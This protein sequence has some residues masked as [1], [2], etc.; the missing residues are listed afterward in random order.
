VPVLR[1]DD[2]PAGLQLVRARHDCAAP[3]V[4]QL[5]ADGYYSRTH[6]LELRHEVQKRDGVEDSINHFDLR[7]RH[8]SQR[9]HQGGDAVGVD[10]G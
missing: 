8:Y 9:R 2:Q 10:A 7:A 3:P 6:V 1:W 4:S 5:Q